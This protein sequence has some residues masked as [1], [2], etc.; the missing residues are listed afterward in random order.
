MLDGVAV[1]RDGDVAVGLQ[2]VGLQ[3][4]QA[5]HVSRQVQLCGDHQQRYVQ[6]C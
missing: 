4:W 3:D 1:L 6:S 2:A 5:G